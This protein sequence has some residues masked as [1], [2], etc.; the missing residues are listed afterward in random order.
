M[1]KTWRVL[2]TVA[3]LLGAFWLSAPP[4]AA[5]E[6]AAQQ[7]IMTGANPAF[8]REHILG[9]LNLPTWY[10]YL[11]QE[12]W[13]TMQDDQG[14]PIP[15]TC[16]IDFA[17]TPRHIGG[18]L[19][20]VFEIL[21]RLA[22][23]VAVVFVIWGGIRMQTSLGNPEQLAGARTTLINALIGLVIVISATVVV[24]FIGHNIV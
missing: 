19:L 13:I 23:I 9:F 14:R 6:P 3:L 22:G 16:N 21:L 18:I 24:N 5:E 2:L 12:P 11:L 15:P 20:A 8:C 17:F 10:K 7:G 1:T 4:A